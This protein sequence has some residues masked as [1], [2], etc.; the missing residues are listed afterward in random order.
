M[1]NDLIGRLMAIECYAKDI[2]YTCTDYASHLLAD[3]VHD[4]ID[5]F[6]DDLKEN[7][8]LGQR[9]LPL[10]SKEYMAQAIKFIPDIKEAKDRENFIS[11]MGLIDDTRRVLKEMTD[12]E[13]VADTRGTNALLDNIGEQLDKSSALIYLQTRI[14][15]GL[16]EAEEEHKDEKK[17]EESK[18][19]KDEKEV[20]NL[21][22]VDTKN[23]SDYKSTGKEEIEI[24]HDHKACTETPVNR[25]EFKQKEQIPSPSQKTALKYGKETVMVA[26]SE[27]NVDR[28][29]NKIKELGL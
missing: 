23:D 29:M 28:L 19:N 27:T 6:I 9:K 20:S 12:N 25:K 5:D 26:E 7:C 15:D 11:L 24:A 21:K 8:F 2:H 17:K 18:D 22:S 10:A 13:D 4:G 1:I 16:N 14:T 3:K